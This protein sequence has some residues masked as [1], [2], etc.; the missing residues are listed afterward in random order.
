MIE[1]I[2]EIA[3]YGAIGVMLLYMIWQHM[4]QQKREQELVDK[5]M[6]VVE[7]NT[8]ALTKFYEILNEEENKNGGNQIGTINT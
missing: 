6:Q 7:N 5:L 3:N 8:A 2:N 1:Y 4:Q